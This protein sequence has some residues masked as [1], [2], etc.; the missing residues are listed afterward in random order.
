MCPMCSDPVTFGGGIT[1][2]YAGPGADGSAW[3]SFSLTQYSAQRDSIRCGSYALAI[4]RAIRCDAPQIPRRTNTPAPI[5]S[6]VIFDYTREKP[7]PSM[8]W[9]KC[10]FALILDFSC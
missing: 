7:T 4:S 5:L 10:N 9:G 2:A 8:K 3:N 6:Y 1:I